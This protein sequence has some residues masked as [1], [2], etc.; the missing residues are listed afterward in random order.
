MSHFVPVF[1]AFSR[2]DGLS[3]QRED[4]PDVKFTGR[5]Q[6]VAMHVAC[7]DECGLE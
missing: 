7:Y 1:G 5:L 3:G 4:S 6:P 2:L